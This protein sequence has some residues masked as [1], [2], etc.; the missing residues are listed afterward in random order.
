MTRGDDNAF[1]QTALMAMEHF[2][3]ETR[4]G[5]GGM[6][7]IW[8]GVDCRD[9]QRVAIK[10]ILKTPGV[11][12]SPDMSA[13]MLLEG[14]A[15]R[16]V[17]H[18]NVA[19]CVDVGFDAGLPFLVLEWL[20]GEDLQARLQR[21]GALPEHELVDIAMQALAG[22]EACHEQGIVH[23]DIKPANIFLVQ[24]GDQT[25]VKLLDFGVARISEQLTRLTQ[26]G[27]VIGTP[28][29]L[30]PEQVRG[31]M[32]VDHRADIYAMGVLLYQMAT[33]QLPF[34]AEEQVAV[35]LK[36]VSET[37]LLPSELRP[38]LSEYLEEVIF[39]A[40]MRSPSERYATAADMAA[41]LGHQ[42]RAASGATRSLRQPLEATPR[43][44]TTVELRLV[45]LLLVD[46]GAG[47]AAGAAVP[48][49]QLRAA[50]QSVEDEAGAGLPLGRQ[51]AGLFGL[52]KSTGDEA[53]RAVR[54][55]LAIC[56]QPHE[57]PPRLMVSTLHVALAEGLQLDG[58]AL[59]RTTRALAELPA[60]ELVLDPK[61]AQLLGARVQLAEVD[62]HRCVRS[63]T[64]QTAPFRQ[65]LGVRTETV[66]R[67]E[68]L[69]V[70]RATARRAADNGEPE[71]TLLLGPAGIGKS[72]LL[73]ELLPELERGAALF[74]HGVGDL[75][76]ART[77]HSLLAFAVRQ[78]AGINLGQ[79]ELTSWATLE[80]LVARFVD[81]HDEAASI[82]DFLGAAIGLPERRSTSLT[83]ARA[84]PELLRQR[85]EDAFAEL[86][87]AAG[88]RGPVVLCLDDLQWGDRESVAL[89]EALLERLDETPLYVLACARPELLDRHPDL[90]QEVDG[91][92]LEI[93][94]LGRR[95]MR[96]LVG[97]IVGDL[98]KEARDLV[99]ARSD[100][101]PYFAE[102][103]ISWLAAN[104]LLERRGE[105][106][107]LREQ[108]GQLELPA[109]VE[110]AIQGRLDRLPGQL[111]EL[112]KSAAVF[113]ESLWESGCE[114]LGFSEVADRLRKLEEARFVTPRPRSRIA[115][116]KEW[117]FRH[118]L[119]Q[120]VAYRMLPT[121]R[122]Q[123]V[124]LT[125]AGWLEEVGE[126]DAELLA[127]HYEEG[128]DLLA[129]ARH[130][131]LAGAS[132]QLKGNLE[133]ALA[134][135]SASLQP[136]QIPARERNRRTLGLARAHYHLG[137]HV[138]ALEALDR[139][140]Q[141]ADAETAAGRVALDAM[142]LRGKVL[143][144]QGQFD[145]AEQVLDQAV[146]A[147]QLP[148]EAD[149]ILDAKY[150][151]F[152]VIWIQGR[153]S[154]TGPVAEEMIKLAG[155]QGRDDQLFAAKVCLA[156][157]HVAEGD[158]SRS[159]ALAREAAGHARTLGH[160]LKEVDALL[161][162]GSTLRMVGQAAEAR[163]SLQEALRLAAQ[164][165]SM[166]HLANIQPCLGG[167]LARQGE[168]EA[169]LAH[170]GAGAKQA[171]ELGNDRSLAIALAGQARA[172]CTW[173]RQGS[174]DEAIG[175]AEQALELSAGRALP[176]EAEARLALTEIHL[177]RG[178]PAA[179][180]EQIQA[181]VR[182]LDQLGVQEEEEMDILLAA[183]LAHA[184]AGQ[185][186]EAGQMLVRAHQRLQT[187]AARISDEAVKASFL[188]DVPANREVATRWAQR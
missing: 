49:G 37:P 173:A 151:L 46:L 121:D 143:L 150:A 30:S 90:F 32:T 93:K 48:E 108:P 184:A 10:R 156:Y 27:S 29:Y 8:R 131:A 160:P 136:E 55:G 182:L 152:W 79:D 185:P 127:R 117:T 51:V 70:V 64:D 116:T 36:I 115:G 178:E 161:L 87:A 171:R 188:R 12:L 114:A 170:F 100:G 110:I 112:L 84:D 78:A 139:L 69:A 172:L 144:G 119:L 75:A 97:A 7:E 183:H 68:E 76:R 25:R 103:L 101:N 163:E 125:T 47:T 28:S 3:L 86:L 146:A 102:E 16:N 113:G 179:A 61:T 89:C 65:V 118:G 63:L 6:A 105:V 72:R 133:Q 186:D 83:M 155:R 60:G 153:Y 19:R 9:G 62:G 80:R 21:E 154:E 134:Y 106:M 157:Y 38:D 96:K 159:V 17:R 59:D 99:V 73:D 165:K 74:L 128:G 77:A 67:E 181:A 91:T 13:R 169:A 71:A 1:D 148:L 26:T 138:E 58:D 45:T 34:D 104:E 174:E 158:L 14:R 22:L 95:A 145:G 20:E 42:L 94:P 187:K 92:H 129:A 23:R 142:V 5:Q 141:G 107:V 180:V 15:M 43:I 177:W 140:E 123:A 88:R 124:H 130:Q 167:V 66:G 18:P 44:N 147:M 85:T 135:F 120:Q 132:S 168:F 39:R 11:E 54:A 122:R 33:G 57:Q 41:A 52:Q 111:K 4:V 126:T 166:H 40:M 31:L 56:A 2:R 149:G 82:A 175:L 137:Q 176:V 35:M 162:L 81:E 109:G 50:V 164:R 24:E 53:L 98:D